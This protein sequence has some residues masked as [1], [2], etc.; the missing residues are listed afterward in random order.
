MCIFYIPDNG[1]FLHFR[2]SHLYPAKR[3]YVVSMISAIL[4]AFDDETI[5]TLCKKQRNNKLFLPLELA[6][7]LGE[8]EIFRKMINLRVKS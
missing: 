7:L 4:K 6:T 5:K 2:Y 1:V 3:T 8:H